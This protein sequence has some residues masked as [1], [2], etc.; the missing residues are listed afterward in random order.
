M[1]AV[2]E[3]FKLQ[4]R[5]WTGEDLQ[6]IRGL[7]ASHPHWHRCRLS[8][9]VAQRWNWRNPSGVLKDMAART[10]LLK[11]EARGLVSLPPRRRP[12]VQRRPSEPRGGVP[13]EQPPVEEAALGDLQP[14][15]VEEISRTPWARRRMESALR[16]FHYLGYGGS[17]GENLQY[18]LKDPRDR[19]LAFALFGAAAWKCQDRDHF[20][21]WTME[22]REQN[23]RLI[24]NNT[25]LLILPWIQARGLGSWFLS[26]IRRRIR[27]DWRRK[28][29]HSVALLETFVEENRFPGT[30]YQAA[31][32][33][34]VGRT[35]GRTR[36]D[37]DRAI[38][39]PL[40][41]IYVDALQ[42][43]FREVLCA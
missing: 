2:A 27:E 34:R 41:A 1:G 17:V 43:N 19:A 29:G 26:R 7:I 16:E 12:P 39:A 35:K 31:N 37:R 14:L 24:A 3:R 30:V 6:E 42:T 32:W 21:G 15:R 40:K 28:Y 25:R 11:L 5:P 22:Q 33:R 36:Q 4:G 9:E 13:W 20:I 8:E 18:C 38:Q 23:L 10:F